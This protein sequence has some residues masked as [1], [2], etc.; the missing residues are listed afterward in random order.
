MGTDGLNSLSYHVK[1]RV[2]RTTFTL[3]QV[4]VLEEKVSILNE[5]F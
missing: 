3:L 1:Q 2:L 4:D 5:I